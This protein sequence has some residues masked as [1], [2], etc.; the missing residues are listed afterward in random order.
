MPLYTACPCRNSKE[1]VPFMAQMMR[2]YIIVPPLTLKDCSIDHQK[3]EK[4]L[5]VQIKP[6]V[7]PNPQPCPIFQ[8]STINQMPIELKENNIWILRLPLVI[9]IEVEFELI[10]I[11]FIN[12]TGTFT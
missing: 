9:K 7:Q 1:S 8:P 4:K 6:C 12:L 2:V 10:S 3:I 5:K 11:F